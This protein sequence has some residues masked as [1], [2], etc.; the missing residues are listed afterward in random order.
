M[1]LI[2]GSNGQLGTELREILGEDGAIYTDKEDLDI[3]NSNEVLEFVKGKDIKYIVNC[4]AYTAVDNAENEK[5]LA[6]KINVIGAKNLSIAAESI[7]AKLIHISTDYVFDGTNHVP[8]KEDD[9]TNPNSI[10]GI[11]KRD[12]EIEALRHANS[13]IILRT[14][15]LYSSH[16]NNFVKTMRKLGK[17]RD[18]IGVIA[19]QIGSPT[20]AAHLAKAIIDIAPQIADGEK[21]IF[22]FTNEGVTSWFDFAIEIMNLS[23]INC[24]VKSIE[25]KDYPTPAKRPHYS[26]LNKEKIKTRFNIEIPHW[27]KGLVQCL[28]KLF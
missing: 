12:G 23:Q 13:V 8:Y 5:S 25:T 18:E 7:N 26:V 3:T 10:Y 17:S 21:D 22:N 27:K 2:T 11:T 16:G 20:Y 15:W 4:A 6:R 14:A 9:Q 1:Y 28:K 24:W 19:D